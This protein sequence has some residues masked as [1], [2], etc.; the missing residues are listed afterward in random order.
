VTTPNELVPPKIV[1]FAAGPGSWSWFSTMAFT[2]PRG[3]GRIKS[4][5]LA[6]PSCVVD[7][8]MIPSRVMCVFHRDLSSKNAAKRGAATCLQSRVGELLDIE[9]RKSIVITCASHDY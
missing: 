7:E 4:W 5:V 9:K 6:T 3:P 1:A 2:A 8:A